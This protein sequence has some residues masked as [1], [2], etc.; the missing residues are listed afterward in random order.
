MVDPLG[1]S[2]DGT[3]FVKVKF[4]GLMSDPLAGKIQATAS[5]KNVNVSSRKFHQKIK[6]I[7]GIIEATT[8]SLQWRDF[9]A[10]YQG[11]KYTLFGSLDDFKEPH[12][13][14]SL[15]GP[16]LQLKADLVKNNDLITI[17][18]L[19]GEYLN[20]TFESKGTITLLAGKG[21]IFDI[22][23]NVSVLLEEL[24]KAL[25]AQQKKNIQPFS[26]TGVISMTADLKGSS[27]DWKDY[28][29]NA[30]ITSPM[31]T[32]MGYKLN[33]MKININQEKG[34]V[35]NLTFNGK[36]YDGLVHA[37]GSLDLTAKGMPYDLALNIDNTD[38]HKLK[39]DSPLKMEEIDGKFFLT[40][41]AHGTLGDFKNNIHTTGS[42]AIKN[43]YLAEFNLFK[44]LLSVLNDALRL[45][46]ITITDVEGNFTIENQKVNTD[47]LRLKGPTIVLLG[48]GWVNFDQMCD[49]NVTVDL[50]S[51]VVPDIA[52]GV[53]NTLNI[54]IYDKVTD[55]KFK[56]KISMPQVINS[57]LKNLLQ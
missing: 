13:L 3:S 16:N 9:T 37:V 22:K 26:P 38:L 49:L 15:E 48:K 1:L 55:P 2:F 50:S 31:V 25:P 24:V 47:N 52:H 10:T 39:I 20:A 4:E 56:R 42:L 41:L 43:G 27:L 5:V 44:G 29:L 57:L 40:T 35:K 30:T 34:K 18:A 46:Q 14:T 23:S 51:G 54:H 12:I 36:L 28:L 8:D 17:N 32:L 45:G 11:Q 21:P 7:T 6:N 53:L 33:D 19:T